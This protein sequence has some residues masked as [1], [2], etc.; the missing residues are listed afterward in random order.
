MTLA[1]LRRLVVRRQ[2]RVCF[3]LAK[4]LECV[5]FDPFSSVL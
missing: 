3:R 4:G 2:L 1:D 5:V